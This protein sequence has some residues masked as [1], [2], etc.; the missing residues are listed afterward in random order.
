MPASAGRP[1]VSVLRVV[2]AEEATAE[3]ESVVVAGEA[4]WE[5]VPVL[6]RLERAF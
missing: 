1:P 4:V 2:P 6:Q 5:V 3:V